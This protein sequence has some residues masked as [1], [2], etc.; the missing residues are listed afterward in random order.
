[1]KSMIAAGLAAALLAGC[2]TYRPLPSVD[3][4]QPPPR[5]RVGVR[6]TSDGAVAL[7]NQIGPD[8]LRL[9]GEVVA[10]DSASLTLAVSRTEAT[11]GRGVDWK[12]ERLTLPREDIANVQ[13]RKLSVPATGLL[14]GLVAGG[15]VA[16]YAIL[17]G[18]GSASATGP[19]A[20]PGGGT[21]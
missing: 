16:A 3:A 18:S 1:M 9:E 8:V 13:E 6:L 17:G 10:S 19:G 20:G 14:G 12:G 5:S 21:Q 7:A 15:L 11:R 4:L 2:Y